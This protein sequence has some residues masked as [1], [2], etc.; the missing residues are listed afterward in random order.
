[1]S[2]AVATPTRGP[3]GRK[4]RRR[5]GPPTAGWWGDGPAPSKRW[6][7]VTIQIEA[8]WN[9][10]RRRW[11]SAD[12]RY[13]YDRQAAENA[14]DFFPAYLSHHIGEFAGQAFT[15]LAYQA[16]LL[17]RP[18]FGWKRA[19]DGLRRFRKV[20]AFIP[21]GGGKSP[22]GAGTGIYCMLCDHEPA[23]EIYAVAADTK[24]ARVVHENAK[25]MVEQSPDLAAMCEVLRDSI[26]YPAT[27]SAYN[28]LSA[29]ASTKHGFRPHVVIFD[30]LHAQPNRDLFEALKRSMVKR[31]QPLLIMI[32]HAGTD[33]E[34]ICYEEYEYAK[35]VLS[36]TIPDESCLP[37]IFEMSSDDDWRDSAVW[38]RVNP[39]HGITVKA[40]AIAAEC[41]EAKV[42]PRKLHDFLRFHGNR[43]V[44]QAAA[45]L[46]IDW[47]DACRVT[48]SDAELQGLTVFAGL[49]MAQKYDLAAFVLTFVRRLEAPALN[50][51]VVGGDPDQPPVKRALSLN[52][53]VT[54]VPFF[55]IP[56]ATMQEHARQDR[57]PYPQWAAQ[58]LVTAT[59]GNMID[60]DRIYRD[61]TGPISARFPRLRQAEI[62][63]DPA[64]ATDIALRLQGHGYK[65]IE[66]LQNYRYLS[67]PSHVF[68]AL[69]RAKRIRHDGQRVLRWNMENVSIKTDDAG[70]IRPVKPKRQAKR[71]DGAVG[72]IMGIAGAI[73][74][75]WG[76]FSL[77]VDF[78]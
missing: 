49:D 37:V 60:M 5:D 13:Y 10:K 54:V 63:Y 68:E 33:D 14:V 57:V 52:F 19:T 51:E 46:P 16:M 44:N 65:M 8:S 76:D 62:R 74:S 35:G 17:T 43:W 71:I 69:V 31:R 53:D 25:I 36:G 47:W 12:G 6:P 61:I 77:G 41:E 66:L 67:E 26:V 40:D 45:W 78:I 29:D 22:W 72:T 48:F 70:R 50:V 56:E 34:G 30:E 20:F 4:R 39:G 15:L 64:F 73:S 24:Q 27:R 75:P 11:E 58:G 55:W 1:M 38:A 7:G 3:A 28:V 21:K 23:A 18:I 9:A 59:E 42:E 32:T 2:R